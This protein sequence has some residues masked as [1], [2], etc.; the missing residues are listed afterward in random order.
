MEEWRAIPGYEAIYEVSN[1]GRVKS[2]KRKNRRHDRVMKVVA[3]KRGYVSILL[4]VKGTAKRHLI[5]RLV[6][7]AFVG[8]CPDKLQ[9]NHKDGDKSNN[10]LENLEYVTAKEN[11]RHKFDVLNYKAPLGNTFFIG[12][13]HHSSK[14]TKSQVLDIRGKHANGNSMA[15][16]ARDYGVRFNTIYSI[17]NNITW[18]F[19]QGAE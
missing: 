1:Q 16:L 7:L 19:Q 3:D 11:S 18:K 4:E 6:M 2:L 5:H 9:V 13:Q 12:E 14:L 8:N 10:S 15:S 17:V